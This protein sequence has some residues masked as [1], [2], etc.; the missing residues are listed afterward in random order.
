MSKLTRKLLLSIKL[1]NLAETGATVIYDIQSRMMKNKIFK[2]KLQRLSQD[3]NMH[4]N[5]LRKI[6]IKYGSCPLPLEKITRLLAKILGL[7]S[8]IGGQYTVLRTDIYLEKSGISMYR[9]QKDLL[10]NKVDN[11]TIEKY[12]IIIRME[13][14]HLRWLTECTKNRL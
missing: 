7:F 12:S 2:G 14:D 5:E 10:L 1:N 11:E 13:E 3:E 4:K 9:R 8:T 6:I